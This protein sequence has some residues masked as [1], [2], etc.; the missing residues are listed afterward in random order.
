[1][2]VHHLVFPGNGWSWRQICFGGSLTKKKTPVKDTKPPRSASTIPSG[3]GTDKAESTQ[4]SRPATA[5]EPSKS[6]LSTT[7][8]GQFSNRQNSCL[9]MQCRMGP[10]QRIITDTAWFVLKLEVV[11]LNPTEVRD[12]FSFPVW[13]HFFSRAINQKVIF[14]IFII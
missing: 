8:P 11:G 7:H 4:T 13:A 12:F 10:G 2:D 6:S 5:P 3:V 1:M 14:G 9:P